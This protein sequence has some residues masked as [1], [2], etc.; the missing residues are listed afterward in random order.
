MAI[1]VSLVDDVGTIC[2]YHR[3]NKLSYF[4]DE[5]KLWVT[6]DEYRDST[7]R[8]LEKA[9]IDSNIA[10]LREYIDLITKEDLD[11][12]EKLRITKINPLELVA[13]KYDKFNSKVNSVELPITEDIREE[14]YRRLLLE[15][16]DFKD[17]VSDNIVEVT[18]GI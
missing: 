10:D 4:V 18:N 6:I 17:G 9:Q 13:N 11:E 3:I 14:V 5:N 1:G 7:F 8:D 12:Y 2:N 16:E 15:I